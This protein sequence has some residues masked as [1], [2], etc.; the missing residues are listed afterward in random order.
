MGMQLW[1]ENGWTGG[2]INDGPAPLIGDMGA[3]APTVVVV[4]G[5]ITYT[6]AQFT[7][8]ADSE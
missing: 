6:P 1:S 8:D 4:G 2:V 3:V 7:I 5:M